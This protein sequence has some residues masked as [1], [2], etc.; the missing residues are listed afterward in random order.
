[1]PYSNNSPPFTLEFPEMSKQ[2]LRAYAAWFHDAKH[3]RA[4]E[5]AHAVKS[6]PGFADWQ[7]DYTPDS[8]TDLGRWFAAEVSTRRR[9]EEEMN[10]DRAALRLPIEIPERTLTIRSY[11]LAMD[12]GMYYGDLVVRNVAGTRWEQVFGSKRDA[13][14]GQPVVVGSGPVPLNPV[15]VMVVCARKAAD[16]RPADLRALFERHAAAL[17]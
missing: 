2:E 1:M 14:Y 17:R 7:L 5:I 11:S 10:A 12:L 16:G 13:D 4:E 3:A 15:R 9:T 6:T 8:L